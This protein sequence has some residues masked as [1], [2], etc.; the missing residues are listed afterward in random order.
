[1]RS[2]DHKQRHTSAA[3]GVEARRGFNVLD[4]DI[5]LA[6][7]DPEQAAG[8]PPAREARVVRQRLVDQCNH[9]V[10]VFAEIGKREGCIR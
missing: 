8:V 3:P 4:R 2:A 9:R 5:G 1:M 10:Y 7:P 6:R